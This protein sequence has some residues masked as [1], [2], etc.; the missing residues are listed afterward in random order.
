MTDE[1]LQ[2]QV[3][4]LIGREAQRGERDPRAAVLDDLARML[5]D[6]RNDARYA[7]PTELI[8]AVARLEEVRT[9]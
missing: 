8:D 1:L 4:V 6:I 7:P 5:E 3:F 2:P 9:R